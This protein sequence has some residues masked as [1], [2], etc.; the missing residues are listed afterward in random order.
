MAACAAVLVARKPFEFLGPRYLWSEDFPIYFMQ[1][2]LYGAK[3]LFLTHSGGQMFFLQRVLAYALHWLPGGYAASAYFFTALVFA[4]AVVAYVAQVRIDTRR[5]W[6]M[7]LIVVGVYASNGEVYLRL[8]NVHWL[9]ALVLIC[10]AASPDPATRWGRSAELLTVALLSFAGAFGIVLAPLFVLAAFVKRTR[11]AT[12]RM[13]VS[14]FCAAWQALFVHESRT[15][16]RIHPE[17]GCW[18]RLVGRDLSGHLF[19]GDWANALQVKETWFI[20]LSLYVAGCVAAYLWQERDYPALVFVLAGGLVL[21]SSIY[22]YR[23]EPIRVELQVARYYFIPTV[24]LGWTFLRM[25]ERS[26]RFR[27]QAIVA[28]ALMAVAAFSRF[29]FP[30]VD[31]PG[32]VQPPD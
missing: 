19:L 6:L 3:S 2:R 26:P 24:C 31:S 21:G 18:A 20:L 23:G 17:D 10:I 32:Y 13:A 11:Y 7:A 22:C 29:P 9:L 8:V 12:V 4:L 1:A 5:R 25:A 16:N 14:L 27:T 30:K 15:F 28:L